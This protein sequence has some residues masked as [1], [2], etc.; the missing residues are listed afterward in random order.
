[1]E[2]GVW[3]GGIAILMAK[4]A[5]EVGLGRRVI[6]LFDTFEGM[7]PPTARDSDKHGNPASMLLAGTRRQDE[8]SNVWAYASHEAVQRNLAAHGVDS[9]RVRTVVGRVEDT[10]PAAA[11]ERIAICRLDTD[12]YELVAHELTHLYPRLSSGGV[13]LIDDYGYWQ[14]CRQA[15]DE[16]FADCTPGPYFSLLASG[17]LAAVKP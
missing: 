12:W 11:P 1:M 16:Y 3:R 15:V 9:R 17:S 14:G 6:H 5:A 13:L 7:S 10:L 2:C 8:L 4:R